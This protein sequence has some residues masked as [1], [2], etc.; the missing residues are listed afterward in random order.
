[1]LKGDGEAA[2]SSGG[3]TKEE[4][5]ELTEIF[6]EPHSAPRPSGLS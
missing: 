6:R 2:A 1:M 3:A 5:V 4:R